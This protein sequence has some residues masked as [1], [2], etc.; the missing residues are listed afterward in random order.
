[1]MWITRAGHSPSQGPIACTS[2][3]RQG[4]REGRRQGTRCRMGLPGEAPAGL[5]S[6]YHSFEVGE[7]AERFNDAFNN[8]HKSIKSWYEFLSVWLAV[9]GKYQPNLACCGRVAYDS[10]VDGAVVVPHSDDWGRRAERLWDQ[11]AVLVVNVEIMKCS[12]GPI[13]IGL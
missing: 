12:E 13:L 1:M 8:L 3:A 4:P 6:A 11:C 7:R 5:P 10:G 9:S 2:G